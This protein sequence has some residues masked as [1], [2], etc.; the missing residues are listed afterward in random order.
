MSSIPLQF[1]PRDFSSSE[2]HHELG[3]DSISSEVFA[4]S[5]VAPAPSAPAK[6]HLG[7]LIYLSE[8][9]SWFCSVALAPLVPAALQYT[10]DANSFQK[11]P[12]SSLKPTCNP[13]LPEFHL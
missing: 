6:Q 11:E 2:S 3:L 10:C 8:P 7:E 1:G 12:I 4:I 13:Q 5:E 9:N